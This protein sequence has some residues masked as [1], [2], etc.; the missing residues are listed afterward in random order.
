MLEHSHVVADAESRFL[1]ATKSDSTIL[2]L[3]CRTDALSQCKERPD[4]VLHERHMS[5]SSKFTTCCSCTFVLAPSMGL[6]PH[7]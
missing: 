4:I 3:G 2:H 1:S 6:L 5:G 7:T